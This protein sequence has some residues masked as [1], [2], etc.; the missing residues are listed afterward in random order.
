MRT[1][2]VRRRHIWRG[3]KGQCDSCPIALALHDAG[4]IDPQVER[5]FFVYRDGE[6]TICS[7]WLPEKARRFIRDFDT[8]LFSRLFCQPF[9]FWI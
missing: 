9:K 8:R 7:R 2:R 1:V 4:F 6:G 3:K 5:D